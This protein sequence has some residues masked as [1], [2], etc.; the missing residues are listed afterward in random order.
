MIKRKY[1]S[2]F[3]LKN[4]HLKSEFSFMYLEI[5]PSS[6]AVVFMHW[7]VVCVSQSISY[8]FRRAKVFSISYT[9]HSVE[10]TTG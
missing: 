5:V 9:K 10:T 4:R 6:A 8:H 7:C 2:F 1:S 3:H